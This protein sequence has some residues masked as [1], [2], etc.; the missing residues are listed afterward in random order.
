M[1]TTAVDKAD[2][3]IICVVHLHNDENSYLF[4]TPDTDR[5]R[6]K[7]VSSV[8]LLSLTDEISDLNSTS[9]ATDAY[10]SQHK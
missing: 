10:K 2:E 3:N 6:H 7:H 4:S 9:S 8:G 5:S 1:A